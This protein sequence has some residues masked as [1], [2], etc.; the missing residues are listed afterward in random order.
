[1]VNLMNKIT[2][3]EST[4]EEEILDGIKF[5]TISDNFLSVYG[6]DPEEITIETILDYVICNTKI[7][8]IIAF[9]IDSGKF[10][11]KE[12]EDLEQLESFLE[13]N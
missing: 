2:I 8:E 10:E 1:M 11:G 6:L 5:Y 13:N 3:D 7:F 9:M 4:L 12:L